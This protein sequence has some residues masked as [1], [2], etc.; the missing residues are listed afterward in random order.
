M[1]LRTVRKELSDGGKR[2][3][4]HKRWTLGDT[5][6]C[7]NSTSQWIGGHGGCDVERRDGGRR[8]RNRG[9]RSITMCSMCL[10]FCRPIQRQ[11][12]RLLASPRPSAEPSRHQLSPPE[13]G[14]G[15]APRRTLGY[16]WQ[17]GAA[18]GRALQERPPHLEPSSPG[19]LN[20]ETRSPCPDEDDATQHE[21]MS[22]AAAHEDLPR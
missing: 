6:S 15:L 19:P 9:G 21:R 1:T 8:T 14:D 22:P 16:R 5:P 3:G 11:G 10:Q 7:V 13:V 20:V 2:S 17:S 18:A 12:A 4:A